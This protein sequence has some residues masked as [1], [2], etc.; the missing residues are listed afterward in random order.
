MSLD[1]AMIYE[2]I[3]TIY[4]EQGKFSEALEQYFKCLEIKIKSLTN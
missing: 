4:Q 2:N 3:G 1:I